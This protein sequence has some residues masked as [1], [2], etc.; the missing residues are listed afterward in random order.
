MSTLAQQLQ[1]TVQ[2]AARE[3][4][5]R[6]AEEVLR[7]ARDNAPKGDPSVDPHP[8]IALEDTGKLVEDDDGIV[9]IFTAPYA[10]KQHEDVNLK[11]PRGGGAKYLQTALES[12]I[13]R[14]QRVVAHDVLAHM[15]RNPTGH[16]RSSVSILQR[17]TRTYP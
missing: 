14:A 2:D 4:V 8:D 11:H 3:G 6:I 15:R 16:R 9:I 1:A 17:T 7:L 10:A 5:R 13:P 12:V